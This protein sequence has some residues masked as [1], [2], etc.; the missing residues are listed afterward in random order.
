LS[1]ALGSSTALRMNQAKRA[2]RVLSDITSR[3]DDLAAVY[4]LD[5]PARVSGVTS[6]AD[7]I[8]QGIERIS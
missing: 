2:P 4:Q 1:D 5:L 6:N 7:E 8:I 3:S